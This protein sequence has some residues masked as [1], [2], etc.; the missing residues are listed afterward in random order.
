[1]VLNA[2]TPDRRAT[3]LLALA[4]GA[5][6]SAS[7]A[8]P[9]AEV[10]PALA[11]SVT[12]DSAEGLLSGQGAAWAAA[13]ETELLWNRTPPLYEGD[14][15]DD[16]Y[17]PVAAAAALRAP[18]ALLVRLRWRDPTE[19][20]PR[21]PERLPDAGEGSIYKQH[22]LDIDRFPD[23]ACVML[24]Q[25]PGPRA[26]LPSL[27]MGERGSPVFLYYW[28][29]ARGFQ[30]LEAAGRGT[31]TRTGEAFP[32]TTRRTKDGWEVVFELPP[33]P[34]GTPLSFA[35]WDGDRAQ[36]DGLKFFSVWY[37]AAQ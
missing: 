9:A 10:A 26:A 29:L 6:F 33:V 34:A 21:E 19:S 15:L 27:M 1:M 11:V 31:T 20:R 24:P 36:R 32:G 23:A 14:P 30:R 35:V 3:V 25:K 17:R 16:G 8:I 18:D 12:E 5:G 13:V 28:S 7:A 22:S 37:E 2:R 4:L